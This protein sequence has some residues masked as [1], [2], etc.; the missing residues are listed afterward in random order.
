MAK[1]ILKGFILVFIIMLVLG[2]T[3]ALYAQD[4]LDYEFTAKDKVILTQPSICFVTSM[5]YGYVYDPNFEDWS[6]SYMYGPFAGTGF[7]VN[8]DTG[9]IV[10]AAHVIE[11]DY[12]NIKWAILD[13]Y[14]FDTYPDDYYNLTDNDWNWI[15]DN[16]K[17]EGENTPEPD[18]EVWVQF[19]TATAGLPDNPGNTYIR[20]EII[21]SSP[22]EQR[23]IAILKIQPVTGR[24][25]SSAIIGDSS[26][27]EIQ[28]NLTIV[29]YPWNADISLE[30]I[31]TPTVTSGIISARKMLEGTELLQVDGTAAF[32]NSGGPVLSENG[33]VIGILTMGTEGINYLRPSNDIKEMLNRNGVENKLGMV[34]DNFASGLAMYRQSHYSEGMKYFDAVLNSS[35]GHLQAQEYKANSQAAI[36]RG[37]DVPLGEE[38]EPLATSEEEAEEESA[39]AEE[40]VQEAEGAEGEVGPVAEEAAAEGGDKGSALAVTLIVLAIVIPLLI[41]IAVIVI[42]V[43]VVRK[44]KTPSTTA[45]PEAEV[46]KETKPGARFC[47]SCGKEV[48][49]NQKFCENCG[50]KLE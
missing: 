43:I 2:L 1:I 31:M 20:S 30:S 50:Q 40:L 42:V 7:C 24:A 21:D 44:R 41:I 9:H 17:V 35:Q 27:V 26:R 4:V 13:A 22:L 45:Q 39:A 49:E 23:D 34:D 33:E 15:Y 6:V 5:Y 10:T 12:V 38:Q 14:I 29:G 16:Y 3:P 19:N 47:P 46:K 48:K 11:D 8:P 25:L 28:D 18:H 37:E 32:G 36:D